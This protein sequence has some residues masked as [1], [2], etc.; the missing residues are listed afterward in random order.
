MQSYKAE[1]QSYEK[2]TD[3]IYYYSINTK[4]TCVQYTS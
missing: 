2:L 1:L 3:N 4:D